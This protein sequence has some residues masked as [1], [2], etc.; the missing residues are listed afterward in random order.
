MV[1]AQVVWKTQT[2]FHETG[3]FTDKPCPC[4]LQERLMLAQ[5]CPQHLFGEAGK[6][7]QVIAWCIV[8]AT[9]TNHVVLE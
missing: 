2:K 4:S 8:R 9:L 5:T 1:P 6:P 3:D 7:K